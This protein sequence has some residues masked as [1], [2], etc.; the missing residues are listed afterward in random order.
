[1]AVRWTERSTTRPLTAAGCE[2]EKNEIASTQTSP[3]DFTYVRVRT[4]RGVPGY[5][6]AH[7]GTDCLGR[8]CPVMG[9][10][11]LLIS[12]FTKLLRRLDALEARQ[13]AL[14]AEN[15]VLRRENAAA[16]ALLEQLSVTAGQSTLEAETAELKQQNEVLIQQNT[17]AA[18]RVECLAATVAT[19]ANS[20]TLAEQLNGIATSLAQLNE[21]LST[22]A[23]AAA[24][25]EKVSQAQLEERLAAAL[26]DKV[27]DAQLEATASRLREKL[28][29]KV[30]LGSTR[31]LETKM[32]DDGKGNAIFLDRHVVACPPNACIKSFR[33][34]RSGDGRQYRYNYEIQEFCAG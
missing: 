30:S 15:A 22:K 26:Q 1:M 28:A 32:N 16:A 18:E 31:T 6:V 33:L 25:E 4:R 14:E 23:S 20:G 21:T 11:G 34:S 27:T 17:A 19:K 24:L 9:D 8:G 12:A 5:R 2:K 29:T 3:I 13:V 10:D 7:G